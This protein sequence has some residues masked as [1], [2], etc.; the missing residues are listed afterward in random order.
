M[1]NV[2]CIANTL[3]LITSS[4]RLL[5]VIIEK[6]VDTILKKDKILTR[7]DSFEM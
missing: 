4:K 7:L 5:T 2:D 6:S 3:V 1:R